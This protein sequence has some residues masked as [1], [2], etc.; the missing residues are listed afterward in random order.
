MVDNSE[1]KSNNLA[2]GQGNILGRLDRGHE[3][4]LLHRRVD[5]EE[6]SSVWSAVFL[7]KIQLLVSAVVTTMVVNAGGDSDGTS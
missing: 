4:G 7:C 2:E 3:L 5:M 6:S 1:Y